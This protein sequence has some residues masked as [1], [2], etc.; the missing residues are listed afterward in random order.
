MKTLTFVE[1]QFCGV[2]AEPYSKKKHGHDFWVKVT[3]KECGNFRN[4]RKILDDEL[5]EMD[6]SDLN[7]LL[8]NKATNEGIA[9]YLGNKLT[10]EEVEVWRFDKGRRFGAIWKKEKQ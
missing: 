9:E 1:G 5:E 3:W 4:F 8:Y 7:F 2:H 10:A 6:H